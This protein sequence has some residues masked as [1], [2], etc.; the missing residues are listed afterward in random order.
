MSFR[1]PNL[2]AISLTLMMMIMTVSGCSGDA[3]GPPRA[4]VSGTIVFDGQPLAEGT[5][6]F[7]PNQ[8]TAGPKVSAA[9]IDG[10]FHLSETHG[11]VVGKHRIEIEA[12]LAGELAMDDEDAF[13][14][15]ASKGKRQRAKFVRIP[16]MYNSQSRLTATIQ[17]DTINDLKFALTSKA[18]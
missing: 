14:Q 3:S 6:R 9:V 7:V 1:L 15:L 11:P 5:I 10:G 18:K 17:P 13:M 16:A 8:G 12:P 4:A 2:A